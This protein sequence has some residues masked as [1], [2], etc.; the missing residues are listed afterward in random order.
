M[1][2]CA[3]ATVGN[4]PKWTC[5]FFCYS[6][7]SLLQNSK[8]RW[9]HLFA[10]VGGK[11]RVAKLNPLL[12]PSIDCDTTRGGWKFIPSAGKTRCFSLYSNETAEWHIVIARSP[13][14]V[15]IL[16]AKKSLTASVMIIV[17]HKTPN[18]ES[19]ESV[20]RRELQIGLL[21][22]TRNVI[23]SLWFVLWLLRRFGMVITC[24][25]YFRVSA[26]NLCAVI[27]FLK[28]ATGTPRPYWDSIHRPSFSAATGSGRRSVR[29]EPTF[30]FFFKDMQI[31]KITIRAQKL[32]SSLLTFQEGEREGDSRFDETWLRGLWP[33]KFTTCKE[34]IFSINSIFSYWWI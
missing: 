7:F 2:F 9:R 28:P 12:Q 11:K 8:R 33:N 31:M 29:G 10:S 6:S 5:E 14:R 24:H 13:R 21:L 15:K 30:S 18:Y 1:Q 26:R 32:D 34:Y 19:P 27:I 20:I 3:G 4:Q 25:G 16:S 22:C 23:I 17:I